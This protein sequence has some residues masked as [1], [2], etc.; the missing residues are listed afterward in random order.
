MPSANFPVRAALAVIA[1]PEAARLPEGW[2]EALE[3]A[4]EH[5]RAAEKVLS[6]GIPAESKEDELWDLDMPVAGTLHAR[7]H[8]ECEGVLSTIGNALRGLSIE[9]TQ[10]AVADFAEFLAKC[11]YSE[12]PSD[13]DELPAY[14]PRRSKAPGAMRE[15]CSPDWNRAAGAEC[16]RRG[17]EGRAT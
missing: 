13:I 9:W 6:A 17:R 3:A 8:A 1:S 10:E 5:L 15:A 2:A 11:Q 7:I 16:W 12:T 14:T 4:R